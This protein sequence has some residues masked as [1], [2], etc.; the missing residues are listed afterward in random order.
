MAK[1]RTLSACASC[2]LNGFS[3]N[4]RPSTQR[5]SWKG[6]GRVEPP[7]W[8]AD[9]AWPSSCAMWNAY[10]STGRR[11]R[12][13]DGKREKPAIHTVSANSAACRLQQ[14]VQQIEKVKSRWG[15]APDVRTV[16]LYEAG[17]DGFWIA[18]ALAKLGFEPLI[19]DPASIPVERH[20][21]RA[22]TDRLDVI[23]LLMCLRAWSRGIRPHACD[24]GAKHRSRSATPSCTGGASYK[25]KRCSTA[26]GYANCCAR[27]AA[28]RTSMATSQ[29]VSRWESFAATTA[30]PASSVARNAETDAV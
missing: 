26:T 17:Q 19:C 18:R 23:R 22:K 13:H 11:P 15:L 30:R 20:A 9:G 2:Q 25:R 7:S 12:L 5:Q 8:F 10:A 4:E 14:V 24:T 27:W 29:R 1:R 16:V 21:R 28:G 6:L 3:N